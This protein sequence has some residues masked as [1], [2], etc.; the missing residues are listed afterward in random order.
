MLSLVLLSV[1]EA[2]PLPSATSPRVFGE[3]RT[4]TSLSLDLGLLPEVSCHNALAL[5]H[6][7]A[8]MMI[9]HLVY[10]S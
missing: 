5:S 6:D 9:M 1:V 7:F 2:L 10:L 4:C 8:L 3:E